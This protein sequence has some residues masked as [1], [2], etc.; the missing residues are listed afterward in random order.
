MKTLTLALF[1]AS[2]L[3]AEDPSFTAQ[4]RANAVQLLKDSRKE[5]IDAV[6]DLTDEQWKW[7][8]GPDR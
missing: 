1:A 3:H 8:P 4:E 5:T 2:F 7:K 6:K